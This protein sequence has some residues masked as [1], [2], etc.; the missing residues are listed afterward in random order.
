MIYLYLKKTLRK[1]QIY[2]SLKSQVRLSLTHI[3]YSST[4]SHMQKEQTYWLIMN[5]LL[6]MDMESRSI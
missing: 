1:S 3:T 5:Y 2:Y 4:H 6:A